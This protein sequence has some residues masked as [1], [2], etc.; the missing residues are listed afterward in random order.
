MSNISNVRF[1][2]AYKFGTETIEISK[3]TGAQALEVKKIVSDSKEKELSEDEGG[4]AVI[5]HVLRS[6]VKDMKE[7]TDEQLLDFPLEELNKLADKIME[8]SG[9]GKKT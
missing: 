2:S 1:T 6:S 9:M 4:L 8:F 7:L 5:F 3:L